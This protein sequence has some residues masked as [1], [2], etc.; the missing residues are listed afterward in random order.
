MNM[1]HHLGT[2]AR[3]AME[4]HD[5]Q[6]PAVKCGQ[7]RRRTAKPERQSTGAAVC[8]EGGFQNHVLRIVA[9]K[10]GES[11]K[12]KRTNPHHRVCDRHLLPNP[13]HFAQI[14]LVRQGVNDRPRA[15][16]QKRLEKGVRGEVEHGRRIGR[17]ASRKEHVA[18]LRT[19]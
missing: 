5:Q 8:C 13:P 17:N 6:P 9:S 4:C 3:R 16:E 2:G 11:G 1:G 19:G 10:E 18:K 15:K 7:E 14:L 12:R